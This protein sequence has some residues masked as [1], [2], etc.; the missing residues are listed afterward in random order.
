MEAS[1]L[2][3]ELAWQLTLQVKRQDMHNA[4]WIVH[5]LPVESRSIGNLLRQK[6]CLNPY[7]QYSL[8]AY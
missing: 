8:S 7:Y 2:S 4:E 6:G 1:D 5:V 3:S